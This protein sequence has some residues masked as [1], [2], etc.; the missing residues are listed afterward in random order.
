[1]PSL[2]SMAKLLALAV[3]LLVTLAANTNAWDGSLIAD[4]FG[5]ECDCPIKQCCDDYC[6]KPLPCTP[7]PQCPRGCDDYCRKPLPCTPCVCPSLCDDYCRKPLPC[8]RCR[9]TA[10][11]VC[12]P[13]RER[14]CL[15]TCDCR[16]KAV[17]NSPL[18]PGSSEC[19]RVSASL[20]LT[21]PQR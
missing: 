5:S 21:E 14:Y 18:I 11:D 6:R 3:V 2:T 16:N 1:M 19:I 4:L 12:I 15:P 7:C 20:E 10:L 8:V 9:S 13:Y 17:H